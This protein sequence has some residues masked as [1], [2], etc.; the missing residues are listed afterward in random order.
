MNVSEFPI[1]KEKHKIN[2][3]SSTKAK[4]N[5]IRSLFIVLERGT[6]K[7][8]TSYKEEKSIGRSQIKGTKTNRWQ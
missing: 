5:Y 2:L 3:L 6:L 1:L 4:I 7:A 8:H